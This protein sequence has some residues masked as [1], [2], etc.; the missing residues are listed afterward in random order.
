MKYDTATPYAAVYVVFRKNGKLLFVKRGNTGWMDG[1]YGSPAG[2]VEKGES[3][4]QAAIREAKEEVGVTISPE[5][6][7]PLFTCHRKD[8]DD[9]EWVD[10]AFEALSWEG[11]AYNAE[12]HLHSKI[13]WLDEQQLPKNVVPNN[14]FV[15]DQINAGKTYGEIGWNA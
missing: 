8:D 13:T 11:E 6:L 4:I 15:I 3:Y 1:F 10:V 12:P 14:K 9:T 5:N 2:K 7:R